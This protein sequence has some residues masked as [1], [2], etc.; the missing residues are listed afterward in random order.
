MNRKK[1]EESGT[2]LSQLFIA[3]LKNAEREF[4]NAVV[5]RLRKERNPKTL[6]RQSPRW[7]EVERETILDYL[8]GDVR[9]EECAPAA[10]YELARESK[11]FRYAA[12]QFK[13]GAEDKI[14]APRFVARGT[15]DDFD[16]LIMQWPWRAIWM[17]PDFPKMPWSKI[18][19]Q[20]K[21]WIQSHFPSQYDRC[22]FRTL[23]ADL[24]D[25]MKVI[26][27]LKKL[28]RETREKRDTLR[29]AEQ[30]KSLSERTNKDVLRDHSVIAAVRND[31]M[32]WVEHIVCT[33]NYRSGKETLVEAFKAW[34][35]ANRAGIIRQHYRPP[36]VKG[37]EHSQRRFYEILKSLT[38]ARLYATLDFKTAK[39]WT[40]ENRR[41]KN[42]SPVPFF[43]QKLRKTPTGKHYIGPLFKERRQWEA[44]M[45]NAQS[46]LAKE[47]ELGESAAAVG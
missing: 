14:C 21:R 27:K 18:G 42:Y 16:F 35:K 10:Y 36:I 9:A 33:L 23:K 38:A 20:E 6:F 47:F 24:L 7:I 29:A 8:H 43:G 15:P 13:R 46:F 12:T 31:K 40:K 25:A 5:K 45:D 26:E 3:E 1:K 28:A 22:G 19:P 17:C 11:S 37:S 34:L 4:K 32:P 39:E 2:F 41:R 44:A 30:G